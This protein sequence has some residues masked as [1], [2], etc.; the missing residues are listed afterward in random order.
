MLS[1]TCRLAAVASAA[2]ASLLSPLAERSLNEVLDTPVEVI[3]TSV[4]NWGTD[5]QLVYYRE[6]GRRFEAD[7]VLLAFCMCND[8]I[9]N[10]P[11]FAYQNK[12]SFNKARFKRSAES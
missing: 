6:E 1:N 9:N 5:Q 12:P 8:V 7:L 2:A 11:G 4:D 10:Y 3:N